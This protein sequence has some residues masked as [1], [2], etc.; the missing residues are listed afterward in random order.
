M[1][2]YSRFLNIYANLPEKLRRGIVVVI[3]DKPYNWNAVYAELIN[4]TEL[5]KLMYQKLIEMEII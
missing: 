4:T 5:G 3:D 2:D 1:E